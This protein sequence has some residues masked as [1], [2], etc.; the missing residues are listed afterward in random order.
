MQA[1]SGIKK[2]GQ[3]A[4][5]TLFSELCQLDDMSVFGPLSVESI[6]K[7]QKK[8]SL[9]AS[10]L[11]KEKRHGKIKG[12]SCEVG[13]P[14]IKMFSKEE[15]ILPAVSADALLMTLIIK[16]LE[17]RDVST[18]DVQGACLN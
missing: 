6:T 7:E 11:I 14:Q 12:Q 2:H 1:S 16:D 9:Q 4:V 15:T 10:N 17:Q 3:K 5:Y 13:R 18:A 8:A